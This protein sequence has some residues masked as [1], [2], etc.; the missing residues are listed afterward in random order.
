MG[1]SWRGRAV[2]DYTSL[3][4][5]AMALSCTSPDHLPIVN[6]SRSR[7]LVNRGMQFFG[8]WQWP[9]AKRKWG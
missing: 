3:S 8:V 7:V 2:A 1:Q 4:T 6:G 5:V 9:T